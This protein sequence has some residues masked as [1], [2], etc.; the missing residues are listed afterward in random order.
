MFYSF[1]K[2]N[3]LLKNVKPNLEKTTLKIVNYLL[4]SCSLVRPITMRSS[5]VHKRDPAAAL[6]LQLNLCCQSSLNQGL[7]ELV[8]GGVRVRLQSDGEAAPS[9]VFNTFH[10]IWSG[11]PSVTRIC[12]IAFIRISLIVC[13]VHFYNI[14]FALRTFVSRKGS[15]NTQND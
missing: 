5:P 6:K 12:H 4:S 2:T 9:C 10:N 13:S 14:E 7:L 3:V 11:V 15:L 8:A 1:K